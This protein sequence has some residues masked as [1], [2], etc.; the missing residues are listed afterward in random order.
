MAVH[1]PFGNGKAKPSAPGLAG[2]AL[3]GPV[4]AIKDMG[5]ILGTDSLSL[6]LN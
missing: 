5:K 6:V 4:K 2:S 3:I 1:N